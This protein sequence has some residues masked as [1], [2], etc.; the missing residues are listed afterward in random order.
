MTVKSKATELHGR[1]L[2]EGGR[3]GGREG[4]GERERERE[5]KERVRNSNFHVP[6]ETAR[7]GG[8]AC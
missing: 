2:Q 5:R 7:S 6:R 3:E 8:G 1:A 4:G